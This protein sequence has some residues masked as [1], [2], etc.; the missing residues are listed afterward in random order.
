MRR[1]ARWCQVTL[2]ALA[3][4]AVW[5]GCGGPSTS[6]PAGPQ[7]S[8][9]GSLLPI[10]RGNGF[11]EMVFEPGDPKAKGR[12]K[13]K[14]AAYFLNRDG[15]G[16]P[17]PAP[18][19]VIFTDESGKSYPLTSKG[20][21]DAGGLRFESGPLSLPTGIEPAGK[22]EAKLGGESLSIDTRPR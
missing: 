12:V 6:G 10:A 8:H 16:P 18:T 5:A 15:S 20:Q 9:G 7:A 22:L 14:V 4:P 17:D 2:L 3:I 21:G 19:D 13:G 1:I 11:V